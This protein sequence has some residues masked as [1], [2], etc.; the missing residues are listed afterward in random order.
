[1]KL[2]VYEL[3]NIKDFCIFNQHGKV[4]YF[5]NT[6][7]TSVNLK[8]DIKINHKSVELYEHGDKPDLGQKLN[9]P[10]LITLY[11]MTPTKH[12]DCD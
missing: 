1:M 9:K 3:Q 6:D 11:A 2:S 8:Q 10:C 5:G 7:L 4:E 12:R